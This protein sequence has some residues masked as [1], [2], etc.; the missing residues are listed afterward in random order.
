MRLE[1]Y[2]KKILPECKN[3]RLNIESG[4]VTLFFDIFDA[5]FRIF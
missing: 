1:G 4:I 3:G 5:L 2:S